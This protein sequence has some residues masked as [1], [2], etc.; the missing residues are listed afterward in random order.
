MPIDSE[1]SHPQALSDGTDCEDFTSDSN[2]LKLFEVILKEDRMEQEEEF[3]LTL[4]DQN[5]SE[6]VACNCNSEQR[7]ET[8]VR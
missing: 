1:N 8:I 2:G 4:C 6:E 7:T 5:L 3:I